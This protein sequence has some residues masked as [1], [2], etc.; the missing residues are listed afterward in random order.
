ME[1]R[2]QSWHVP[3]FL[4]SLISIKCTML[5]ENQNN[6]DVSA[7]RGNTH[8]GK[9]LSAADTVRSDTIVKTRNSGWLSGSF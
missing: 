1:R 3:L 5:A 6:A 4:D 8:P 7:D 2:R 9:G